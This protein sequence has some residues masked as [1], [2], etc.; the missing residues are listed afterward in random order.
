MAT[1]ENV[2]Y[3]FIKNIGDYFQPAI[4]GF[5]FFEDVKE[6][7][8]QFN[9]NDGDEKFSNDVNT[10]DIKKQLADKVSPLKKKFEKY[11]DQIITENSSIRDKINLTNKFNSEILDVLGYSSLNGYKP[12]S[13][14]IL[15]SNDNNSIVPIRHILHNNTSNNID[16]IVMEMQ[17]LI[18]IGDDEPDGL[19]E[20]HYETE[21]GYKKE[22]KNQRYLASQWKDVFCYGDDY[23]ISPSRVNEAITAIFL[24]PNNHAPKYILMLA[25]NVVFLFDRECWHR[26][27]YLEISLEEMFSQATVNS[28]R[29]NEVYSLFYMLLAKETLANNS[30]STLLDKLH[31]KGYRK[32][33]NVT[34][35]LKNGVISA[36]ETLANELVGY[37]QENN[38]LEQV[39]EK[40]PNFETNVRDDCLTMVYRLLFIFYAESREELNIL[41][42]KDR[43]YF[44]G[45]S[46]NKLRDLELVKLQKHS[47]NGYYFD[48]S[49]KMLFRLMRKKDN[50]NNEN[51]ENSFNIKG[52]DLPTFNDNN[53]H[54]FKNI[55][56]KNHTWQSIIKSLSLSS[57]NKTKSRPLRISYDN[58]GINQLGFVYESLL[59]FRL[60]Y[61]KDDS[62]EVHSTKD[63]ETTYV[64]EYSRIDTFNKDEI[65]LDPET[66]RIK[67]YN[68]GKFI[69]RLSSADRRN[70]ASYYTPEEL[71]KSTINYTLK[72]IIKAIEDK[73]VSASEDKK[74]SALSILELKI[75][76]PAM[77]AAA[78]LNEVIN[79]LAS[80]YLTY[81][82]IETNNKVKPNEY[83]DELQK[84]KAYIANNNVYGIDLNETAI[85]LG[86]LSLLL[87]IIHQNME[88]PFLDNKLHV[89][90][91]TIGAWLKVYT[92]NQVQEKIVESVKRKNVTFKNEI[93]EWWKE[94]PKRV[95][96]KKLKNSLGL[97]RNKNEIYYFLLPMQNMLSVLTDPDYKKLNPD[98]S[99]KFSS[100]Q[101]DWISNITEYEFERL[102]RISKRIDELL[103]E[104]EQVLNSINIYA[105]SHA[106]IWGMPCDYKGDNLFEDY[107]DKKNI[108]SSRTKANSAY[109][110]LKTV[111]D[112]WCA[113]WYWDYS[114]IDLLPS[115]NEY[116]KDIELLLGMKV[117]EN[118]G[119]QELFSEENSQVTNVNIEEQ[120]FTTFSKAELLDNKDIVEPIFEAP[121]I[122]L[123]ESKANKYHF[124]HPM[125][126]FID[127]FSQRNGFDIVCG[128][129]PWLV[130]SFE[131]KDILAE[132]MPEVIVKGYDATKIKKICLDLCTKET[133]FKEQYNQEWFTN[134]ASSNFMNAFCNYHLLKGQSCDLYKC[135]IQN[136]LNYVSDE[137]FIGLVH[138]DSI[139]SD[140][141]GA[142][143]RE[144]IYPHLR[145]HFRF[146]NAER[147]FNDVD[148]RVIYAINI[149]AGNKIHVN[150]KSIA[151]LYNPNT[152]DDCFNNDGNG[153]CGY[154][155]NANG[156][157]NK[158]GHKNRIITVDEK[159][160]LL[161]AQ[162]FENSNEW[163]S[164]KLQPLFSNQI[165]DIIDQFSKL[166]KFS[167]LKENEDF[168][169]LA[170]F[171]NTNS[172]RDG[173]FEYIPNNGTRE[174][175]KNIEVVIS[176]PNFTIAN[177]VFQ[178]QKKIS[179]TNGDYCNI[180]LQKLP[181]SFLPRTKYI[182]KLSLDEYR[183]SYLFGRNSTSNVSAIDNY[184]LYFR[185]MAKYT[186]SRTIISSIMPANF[187][188]I[189]AVRFAVCKEPLNLVKLAAITHSIVVDFYYRMQGVERFTK[190]NNLNMPWQVCFEQLLPELYIRTLRL[191]ALTDNYEKLWQDC[192]LDA[193]KSISW[194]LD[195]NRL[196]PFENLQSTWNYDSP[197][198]GAYERRMALVEID[199][200]TAMSFGFTLDQLIYMYNLQ[201]GTIQKY[202]KDTWYDINGRIV[203]TTNS[204]ECD[205]CLTK[206][207]FKKIQ[208]YQVGKTYEHTIKDNELYK[209]QKLIYEAPFKIC[210]RVSD[211]KRA[212]EF[213]S[214]KYNL[215][216]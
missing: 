58:L 138:P 200:L 148:S 100:M 166:D 152:I 46:L 31:E 14:F 205:Y 134:I 70:S 66:N 124:L 120:E 121:R 216:I 107:S 11:R 16:L 22:A 61:L 99:K 63:S 53:L 214:K 7:S 125:L 178:D 179:K 133:S 173:F 34:K 2:N 90:N 106:K 26:G 25:G 13:P 195:D 114:N 105:K 54:Y 23:K 85:E 184:M 91:A 147:L 44:N 154:I 72:N 150:F 170:G 215:D 43:T 73:K 84:V 203:F 50:K 174:P 118:E 40:D 165:I 190:D 4:F 1:T 69:Y 47:K 188:T 171:N 102:L 113:L 86:K 162:T 156:S 204:S 208:N 74:V 116:W 51:N 18:R 213:F 169:T 19:F 12:E 146:E 196:S 187:L 77:G 157:L 117:S 151:N 202:E 201:F 172:I 37:L 35:E 56:I 119:L 92:R 41:P 57:D 20:Q 175:Q 158:T 163:Q 3:R 198:R 185:A 82:Q 65:V 5:D 94:I 55:K 108:Y 104:Y 189:N 87:N 123:I 206:D 36:I 145:Y 76:E 98:E 93:T 27:A 122:K 197:L 132:K 80:T 142:Q 68:K 95:D 164:A 207:E 71:T 30:S 155:K 180:D 182:T 140:V 127:V 28:N 81:I 161:F 62:I 17:N 141:G 75:L 79:Q 181:K 109:N 29:R 183:K 52:L 192:W 139:Y 211:Y 149:Y 103:Y 136:S 131:A 130:N 186:D 143:L 24:E 128:N 137:G 78:F 96:F 101:K 177:P 129:P 45:Y 10:S 194:S 21:E 126:E 111:M 6:L 42:V 193:Y 212:W 32:G 60:M 199:V 144:E 9:N 8:E 168:A 176:G 135:I 15:N 33:I 83:S 153:N 49:L 191:N 97:K 160:L 209:D 67:V 110:R 167:S 89:G 38:Q 159:L 64:T 39:L 88:I 59:A 115:R 112:Y 210:D 48:D